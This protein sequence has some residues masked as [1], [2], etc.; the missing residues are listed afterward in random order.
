LIAPSGLL[1]SV[2]VVRFRIWLTTALVSG[3]ILGSL[4]CA[5][6]DDEEKSRSDESERIETHATSSPKPKKSPS[7]VTK[8]PKEKSGKK[9]PASTT[10]EKAPTAIPHA[11]PANAESQKE[12][13][14]SSKEKK[15]QTPI[16]KAKA[17]KG[18][19]TDGD[20]AD[21]EESPR[22]RKATPKS[23]DEEQAT[24]RPTPR[25]TPE[26]TVSSR[27]KRHHTPTPKPKSKK[28]KEVSGKTKAGKAKS[29][30]KG[31]GTLKPEK[32][33][34]PVEERATTSDRP[35]PAPKIVESATPTPAPS[36]QSKAPRNAPTGERAQVVIEK[37]GLE[38]DQGL[39][40]APSPPPRRGFWP[41]SRSS[42]NYRYLTR[43]V[44]D[45]IRRAPVKRRRWQF[46]VV[47]NSGTRQGNARVFDYYHRHV[48][49]MQNGLAYHFVIGNGTSTGNG[50]IEVGDRWRRQINGGHVHS[51]YLNNISLGICLVGDFNRDRPTRAQ[52]D[53]CEELIRYLRERCG[54]TDRG[55]IPVRP[56]RE[57]NPPRWPTDCPGDDFPYSWFRRF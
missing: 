13:N 4:L 48:R 47:H 24:P 23:G 15:S 36:P 21:A 57:M 16:P 18:G 14:A 49:R 28:S 10:P 12:T 31:E 33:P 5:Q 41:W 43:S 39:E 35:T 6:V 19:S 40:P 27:S 25:E 11:K 29:A 8:A 1:R 30:R 46:I 55:A 38:E 56:H 44:I 22:A 34:P 42:A 17:V 52:L 51:D 53:S 20:N 54:K 7:P 45:A 9:R 3:V 2:A 37:S 26:P 50:Q 32:T